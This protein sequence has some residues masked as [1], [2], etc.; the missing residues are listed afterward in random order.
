MMTD[1]KALDILRARGHVTGTPDI[2][3]GRVRVWIRDGDEAVDVQLGRE[4]HELAQDKL[5]LEEIAARRE[6]EM[7]FSEE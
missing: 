1:T 6:D 7:V 4:L 2:H 5:S 3:T